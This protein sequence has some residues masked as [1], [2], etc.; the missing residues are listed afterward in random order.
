MLSI[1]ELRD[2]SIIRPVKRAVEDQ[3]L[4]LPGVVAVDI[5]EKRAD[6]R[7]TGEQVIV[8]SVS[9]K[10]RDGQ[11]ATGA[12]VPP[13]ILGIPTDVIEE[14]PVVQHDHRDLHRTP[15][16]DRYGKRETIHGGRGLAPCRSVVPGMPGAADGSEYRRVGTLGVLVLGRA[17]ALT[18]MGLTTFDV[19]CMDDAWAVGDRMLDP[20]TGHVYAGLARAALSG[21]V[22]AAAVTIGG[23]VEHSCRVAGIGPITGQCAAYPGETVRKSGYGTGLTSGTVTSTD[24]TVRVDH[25]DALGVRILREQVRVVASCRRTSFAGHG[26]AGAALVNA[27]GRVIGLHFGSSRD[28]VVGFACPISDVLAELDVDLCVA[29]RWLGRLR[30]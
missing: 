25:G 10:E 5:G 18:A 30:A 20:D 23:N 4:D 14:Q 2:R 28:G 6:M 3:L 8:V 7:P 26:D 17:P 24:V 27:E 15:A 1:R 11:I 12:R 9:R 22:N 19:A 21:R 29:S 16:G 13:S